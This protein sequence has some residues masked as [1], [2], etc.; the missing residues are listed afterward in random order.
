M[1]TDRQTRLLRQKRMEGKTQETAAA[2]GN[3]SDLR[4]SEQLAAGGE[5][6]QALCAPGAEDRKES[7]GFVQV[8]GCSNRFL[9][10]ESVAQQLVS[11]GRRYFRINDLLVQLPH[12]VS[13]LVVERGEVSFNQ[14][15][16]QNGDKLV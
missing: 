13:A 7:I 15:C 9:A 6:V 3:C 12:I 16:L 4:G 5:G 14:N 11:F 10:T 2:K 1:I 8:S